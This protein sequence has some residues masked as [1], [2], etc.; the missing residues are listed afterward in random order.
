[1]QFWRETH[2]KPAFDCRTCGEMKQMRL[3]MKDNDEVIAQYNLEGQKRHVIINQENFWRQYKWLRGY[4]PKD[5]SFSVF[6]YCERH[7]CIVPILDCQYELGFLLKLANDSE[8]LH[9]LPWD[10]LPG[11]EGDK[12]KLLGLC[13]IAWQAKSEYADMEAERRE[14]E[15]K[16]KR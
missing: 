11:L 5:M 3:C 4:Y 7:V 9:Q 12:G 10:L 2:R 14:Q 15:M 6:T 8:R 16:A 1:V 13:G